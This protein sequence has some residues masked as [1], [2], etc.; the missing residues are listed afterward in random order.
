MN[1][2]RYEDFVASLMKDEPLENTP[3]MLRA[4]WHAGRDEW[5]RAHEIVQASSSPVASW[6]HAYLH[7]VEG[8]L[9]NAG[10]WYARAGRPTCDLALREEWEII[11]RSLLADS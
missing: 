11:V 2:A 3:A 10:Y 5:E 1:D 6:I 4:L 8:D 9:A 7:R